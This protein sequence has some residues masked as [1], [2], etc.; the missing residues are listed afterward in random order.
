MS[1]SLQPQAQQ[2]QRKQLMRNFSETDLFQRI[3]IIFIY[4]QLLP[5]FPLNANAGLRTLKTFV[6]FIKKTKPLDMIK[7]KHY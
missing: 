6:N 4:R 7:T 5:D 2:T 1:A 3:R